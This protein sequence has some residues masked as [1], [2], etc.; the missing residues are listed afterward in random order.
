M[1]A[2]QEI[3]PISL[4]PSTSLRSSGNGRQSR[5]HGRVRAAQLAPA[6]AL[7]PMP[8]PPDGRVGCGSWPLPRCL[9]GEGVSA[10]SEGGKHQAGGERGA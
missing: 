8:R 2:C 9:G 1:E 3:S 7:G 5:A 4:P 6:P 10:A